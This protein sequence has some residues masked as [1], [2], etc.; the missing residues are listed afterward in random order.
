MG[1][2]VWSDALIESKILKQVSIGS[3]HSV[4]EKYLGRLDFLDAYEKA[5]KEVC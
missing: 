5:F 1:Y 4:Y 2:I 3:G